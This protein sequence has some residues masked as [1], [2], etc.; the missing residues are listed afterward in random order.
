M[1]GHVSRA[2]LL[3]ACL[4]GTAAL[5]AS[6]ISFAQQPGAGQAAPPPAV[7][8]EKIEVQEVSSPARFTARVEAIEAVDIRARVTGF[9]RAV[10]FKDGQAVKAGDTSV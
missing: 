1:I 9:L 7:V 5:C 10:T 2:C 3:I 4:A 8:V 6:A